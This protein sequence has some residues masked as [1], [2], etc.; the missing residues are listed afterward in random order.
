MFSGA[1]FDDSILSLRVDKVHLAPCDRSIRDRLFYCTVEGPKRKFVTSVQP[2]T[3][4][5]FD[6]G[7]MHLKVDSKER[8]TIRLWDSKYAIKEYGKIDM[9]MS[10]LLDKNVARAA[11]AKK[12]TFKM[13][14]LY[15]SQIHYG[16]AGSVSVELKL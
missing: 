13:L 10:E 14:D 6:D 8:I 1:F 5:V 16:R 3:N 7:F 2:R 4:L 12:S 11:I 15:R 9:K